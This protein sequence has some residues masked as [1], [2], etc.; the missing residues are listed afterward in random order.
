M[1][2]NQENGNHEDQPTTAPDLPRSS[3]G[4]IHVRRTKPA[5]TVP[6]EETPE[7][8]ASL[9]KPL[10]DTFDNPETDQAVD[11]I[12]ARESDMV[13]AVDDAIANRQSAVKPTS[14]GWRNK[15][16]RIM[17]SKWTWVFVLIVLIALFATPFTRYK[18]LG[19]VV[20]EKLNISVIDEQTKTPVSDATITLAGETVKTN[21]NGRVTMQVGVGKHKLVVAKHYYRTVTENRFVGFSGSH[22]LTVPMQATGRLIGVTITNRIS[23]QPLAGAEV[24]VLNTTAK[25]N[26][27]GHAT[28]AMPTTHANDPASISLNGYNTAQVTIVVTTAK[29]V[30][31]SF[32]LT[33]AGSIYYLLNQGGMLNVM[34]SNL[35]GSNRTVFIAGTGQ[36]ALATTRL[37][38][39]TDWHYL[40]LEANRSGG[41][42]A[43]YLINTANKQMTGF[44]STNAS[45]N[46][47]GWYGHYF[48]YSLTNNS[49]NPWQQGYEA[50]KE[51]RADQG[52][53]YQLDQNQAVGT[54]G[55]YATQN[56][57]NFFITSDGLSYNTQWITQGGYSLTTQ[58]DALRVILLSGQT[59][60]DYQSFIANNTGQISANRFAPNSVYFSI[61]NTSTGQITYYQYTNGGVAPAS[62]N[63]ATFNQTNPMYV[64]SPS[65]NA[66]AWSEQQNGQDIIFTGNANGGSPKQV[67]A[68]SG[69]HVYGW[70]TDKYLL[71]D[72]GGRLYIIP[73][74]GLSGGRQPLFISSYSE[75]ASSSNYEYGGF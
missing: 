46:L 4:T 13:L 14:S 35:D 3:G 59:P 56:L 29:L 21:G 10:S 27:Q 8:R 20:K 30:T 57:A 66:V 60:K 58:N 45:F 72:R 6:A 69:Y 31:N 67:A 9:E 7:K 65:G 22:E 16:K 55:S 68:L 32:Q 52:E 39:S 40:L 17:R 28:I 18:I 48:I 74:S 64:P 26:S 12:M 33:P 41:H 34:K 63:Q 49:L 50:V 24:H 44:D 5:A 62:I 15:L 36:E 11:D 43:L 2:A 51:Y 75:P 23:G 70:Y 1:A 47:I 61:P 54:S 25:T 73:A 38:A 42:Q 71:L 37:I 19:L 53:L